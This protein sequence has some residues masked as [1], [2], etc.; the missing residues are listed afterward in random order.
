MMWSIGM[1]HHKVNHCLSSRYTYSTVQYPDS[2]CSPV[3][4]YKTLELSHSCKY[5]WVKHCSQQAQQN[6]NF[7]ILKMVP[8]YGRVYTTPQLQY[9]N[10]R[11]V[12]L[13]TISFWSLS[14][15]FFSLIFNLILCVPWFVLSLWQSDKTNHGMQRIRLKSSPSVFIIRGSKHRQHFEIHQNDILGP[16]RC[17]ESLSECVFYYWRPLVQP[18]HNNQESHYP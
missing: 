6:D 4:K 3:L 10:G 12:P 5:S 18:Y 17:H 8:V 11:Y 2:T 15:C 1:R 13:P 7:D 14:E 9:N 16:N